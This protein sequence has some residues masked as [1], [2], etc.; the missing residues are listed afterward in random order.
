[1][2]NLFEGNNLNS[3]KNDIFSEEQIKFISACII[4]SLNYLRIEK[5]FK[6]DFFFNN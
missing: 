4:Q 1:M 3:F 5:I 2:T 6:V